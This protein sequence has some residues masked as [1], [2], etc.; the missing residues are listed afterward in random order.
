MPPLAPGLAPAFRRWLE[1]EQTCNERLIHDIFL[2]RFHQ[3]STSRR[4]LAPEAQPT[5]PQEITW[6]PSDL[7]RVYGPLAREFEDAF[8]LSRRS[9]RVPFFQ[10]PQPTRTHRRLAARFNL[11]PLGD[12]LA[13]PTASYRSVLAWAEGTRRPPVIIK[14]SIGALIGRRQRAFREKQIAR[15]I[16]INAFLDLI[17]AQARRRLRFDW[18]SETAGV[19][20][21][22]SGRGCLIRRLPVAFERAGRNTLIPAFALTAAR[23]GRRPLLVELIRERGGSPEEYVIEHLLAPYVRALAFLLFEEGL[24][25]EGHSQ[26]VLFEITPDDQLSG[27]LFLRDLADTTANLAFRIAREKAWPKFPPGFLPKD[28]PFPVAGNAADYRCDFGGRW[29]VRGYD[30]VE[31]YG[32]R[33]F[34][35][36]LNTALGRHF[37]SYRTDKVERRY[38]E[39]W[40]AEAVARLGLRPL[41]RKK[42][43]GLAT[44][45]A[46]SYFLQTTDWRALG[47]RTA[48]LPAAAEP[49]LI[50]GRMRRRAGPVYLRVECPWGDLF[51]HNGLPGFFRPAF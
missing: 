51:I 11:E 23:A 46:F 5:W 44:D 9:G 47:G 10:H 6:L 41:F 19:V 40:Q 16:M 7:A 27:R 8:G 33:G 31:R 39:L 21:V 43:P 4:E 37:K 14:H 49:I 18:F 13:S 50:E 1:F 35:W 25:Y 22:E 36:P 30:T 3:R 48:S 15:A 42:P 2:P 38:L 28:A 29:V 20:D 12:F 45:E 34:V 17:P 32:L 24:Q 26:N